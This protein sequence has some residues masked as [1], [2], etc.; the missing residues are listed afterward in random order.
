MSD[1]GESDRQWGE[2]TF[3]LHFEIPWDKARA[4]RIA[5]L[6]P[7]VGEEVCT[8]LGHGRLVAILPERA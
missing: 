1:N 6:F 3:S 8:P 7:L 4:I 5:R 2:G